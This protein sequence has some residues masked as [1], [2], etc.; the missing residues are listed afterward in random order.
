MFK[1]SKSDVNIIR[2]EKAVVDAYSQLPDKV[3]KAMA[4]VTFNMGQNGSSCDVKKALST[5]PKVLR[6]RI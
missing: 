6:K 3:Q 2:D 5:L 1:A 4:D